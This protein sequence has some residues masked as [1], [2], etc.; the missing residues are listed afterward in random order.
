LCIYKG[1]QSW[2]ISLRS[3]ARTPPKFGY[4]SPTRPENTTP[5]M[6]QRT[7]LGPIS[8]NKTTRKELTPLQRAEITTAAAWGVSRRETEKHYNVPNPPFRT[9][10]TRPPNE[11]TNS[12]LLDLTGQGSILLVTKDTCYVSYAKT[13]NIPTGSSKIIRSLIFHEKPYGEFSTTMVLP[14]GGLR[15][16]PFLQTR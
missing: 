5:T 15:S 8:G 16:V 10:S 9:P 6:S 7:P 12:R 1:V 11:P 14:I 4:A 13:L 2:V 3:E